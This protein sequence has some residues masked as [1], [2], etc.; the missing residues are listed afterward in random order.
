MKMDQDTADAITDL[1]RIPQFETFV[2]WLDELNE[3]FTA[4]AIAGISDEANTTPDVL[5]GRAQAMQI[6]KQQMG[7][8]PEIASRIK[9]AK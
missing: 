1:M 5:R 2:N 6:I 4:H 7:K 3:G 9:L 8:A